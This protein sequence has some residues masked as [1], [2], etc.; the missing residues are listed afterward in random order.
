MTNNYLQFSTG[1]E[2][3]TP[4]EG[5]LLLLKA[6]ADRLGYSVRKKAKKKG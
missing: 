2:N 4:E 6:W 3:I 1:I 5:Q